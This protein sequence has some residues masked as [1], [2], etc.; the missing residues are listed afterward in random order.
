MSKIIAIYKREM[1]YYFQSVA[2]YASISV[3]LA[4][5]GYFFSSIFKYYNFLS[6]EMRRSAD[7]SSR[8]N[9]IDGITRPLLGNISILILF[10]VPILTM[11][12]LS[13]EKKQG[14]FELLMT[15]PV[16]ESSVI[17]GKFLSALTIFAVMIFGTLLYPLLLIIYA[18]PEIMPIFSGYL[19]LFLVGATFISM[20][21]FFSSLSENQLVSG[22]LTL[23][24][25]LFFLLIGWLAPILGPDLYHSISQLSILF[26][27]EPFAKGIIDTK[28]ISYYV[29]L[30]SLFLFMSKKSLDS[31]RYKT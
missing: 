12:L 8:L 1:K 20:G 25:A 16:S 19:G 6:L 23:G 22:I 26:H 7:V 21:L 27:F 28:D 14:T 13:E 5:S 10:T 24:T 17:A 18:E 30:T 4:I 2:A 29:L 11:R 9:I 3:F 31:T 15:Y